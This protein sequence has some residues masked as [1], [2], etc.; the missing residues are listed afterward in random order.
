VPHFEQLNGSLFGFEQVPL[1]FTGELA[2]QLDAQT[3]DPVLSGAQR[4]EL[5][6]QVTPQLPQFEAAA[7]LRHPPSH[8]RRPCRQRLDTSPSSAASSPLP[9]SPAC[10]SS[11]V[12]SAGVP[13][14]ASAPESAGAIF[15][16]SLKRAG[17]P[18]SITRS[19]AAQTAATVRVVIRTDPQRLPTW[20]QATAP[21]RACR[22]WARSTRGPRRSQ[23]PRLR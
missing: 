22:S 7:G 12:A 8:E 20:A 17:H 5:L 2:G 10:V 11:S 19:N 16:S 13:P 21:T 4:A 15:Q 1:Q 6:P 9:V 23:G 3:N 14:A 18:L